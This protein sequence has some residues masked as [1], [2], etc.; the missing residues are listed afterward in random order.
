MSIATVIFSK[1]P[2]SD[3][4]RR[5][6]ECSAQIDKAIAGKTADNSTKLIYTTQDH[7][8]GTYVRNPNCWAY[9][10]DLTPI[11]PWN[12]RE[13]YARAGT[14][15]SPRHLM[16]T[17]H[18]ALLAGN[19]VRFVTKDNVM[20]ERTIAACHPVDENGASDV[21]DLQVCVL[22]SD[23]PPEISFCRVMGPQTSAANSARATVGNLTAGFTTDQEEKICVNEWHV[24]QNFITSTNIPAE[25]TKRKEFY[26]D[27]IPYDSGN[28]FGIVSG[29]QLILITVAT[30]GGSGGGISIAHYFDTLNALMTSLGNNPAGYQ[31]TPF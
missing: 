20:V 11:S 16:A 2:K 5:L 3:A 8:T 10:M 7:A 31:L 9:G 26:E 27:L 30:F 13:G 14:L 15:V 17:R 22:D 1:S 29:G 24:D 12:S 6:D 25:G 23:V 21:S 28:P 4:W 18:F 19:L